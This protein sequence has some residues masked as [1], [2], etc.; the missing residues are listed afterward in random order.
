MSSLPPEAAYWDG[1]Y[2]VD[3]RL[4][5]DGPSELA[6]LAV[7]RLRPH[8]SPELAVLDVGCG[9]GRDTRYIAAEL[10]CRALGIDPSPRAVA[11]GAEVA[12][13]RPRC[14]VRGRRRG[15]AG[16]RSPGRPARGTSSTPATSTT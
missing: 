16:G 5:G 10:R 12:L 6:R 9:Y 15:V 4:W 8:A 2:A 7:A 1:R 11:D 13:G 14:G 3:G